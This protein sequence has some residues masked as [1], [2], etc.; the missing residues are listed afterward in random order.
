MKAKAVLMGAAAMLL[1]FASAV[2]VASAET[3]AIGSADGDS[4][5]APARAPGNHGATGH[6]GASVTRQ[7]APACAPG[8]HGATGHRGAGDLR[9]KAEL[10]ARPQAAPGAG[11]VDVAGPL[12]VVK[13]SGGAQAPKSPG[14]HK[15]DYCNRDAQG[16]CT[17][18]VVTYELSRMEPNTRILV[19]CT[20]GAVLAIQLPEGE[21]LRGDPAIGNAAIFN[22]KLQKEPLSILLWPTI[23]E[24]SKITSDQL[25]G[26]V[27]NVQIQLASGIN[28]IIEAKITFDSPV[29]RLV[30]KHPELEKAHR[31]Q[32]ELK[33]KL[34]AQVEAELAE[35]RRNLE[36]DAKTESVKMMA[37]AMLKRIHCSGLRERAMRDLLVVWGH[38][39]CQIGDHVFIEF[40]IHNRARDLFALEQLEVQ[41][42]TGEEPLPLEAQVAWEG[43]VA[44]SLRF[45]KRVKGVAVFRVTEE[46]A[47]SEY[48]LR[49]V[50]ASG[51][52]REVVLR[53][54]SF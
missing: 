7:T 21:K 44:P 38:R 10:I 11:P 25:D 23:P 12:E 52:K 40:S 18:P 3:S 27:S 35:Q 54:I 20:L 37:R 45:D 39:I 33:A 31:E 41:S 15:D 51:K 6:R 17:D 26:A 16:F 24:K 14:Q 42:S 2:G 29:Q 22:Y 19:N 47:G 4:K 1:V 36:Q 30:F 50:E 46:T 48:A 13:P 53:G 5:A 49:V 43:E 8:N 32:A 28:I 9:C 34:R